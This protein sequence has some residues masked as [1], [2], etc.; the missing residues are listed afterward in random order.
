M[1]DITII[2][3]M[4]KLVIFDMDGTILDTLQDMTDSCN[5]ILGKY[6]FPLHT[7]SEYKFFVGN[8]IPKLIERALPS[9]TDAGTREKVLKDFLEYYS[10]HCADKTAPYAGIVDCIKQLKAAG[11][12]IA[13]NTNKVESAAVELCKDYFP[14][15]F[16][17]ISGSRPGVPPKP[18]PTGLYEILEKAGLSLEEARTKDGAVF[19]GD[20][21][22]DVR[23]GLNAGLNVIGVDWGFRG[24]D[25]LLKNDCPF[26]VD[27]ASELA[28]AVLNGKF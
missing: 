2:C 6:G 24:R 26:V 12:K 17:I 8:G 5:Y 19:V 9:E 28:A 14:G 7:I 15:L 4:L 20:S 18:D 10:L 21:D 23:T 27:N 11:I 25:F 13:V 22:V 3:S 16:D 1:R